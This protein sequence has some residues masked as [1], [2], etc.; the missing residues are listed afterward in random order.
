VTDAPEPEAPAWQ[1]VD[2][3]RH[4]RRGLRRSRIEFHWTWFATVVLLAAALGSRRIP[5]ARP[6]WP[7]LTIWATAVGTAVLVGGSLVLHEASHALVARAYGAK[8]VVLRFALASGAVTTDA[9]QLGP[10]GVA[11]TAIAGPLANAA[12]TLITGGLALAI[13]PNA[14]TG[15]LLWGTPV[16][17]GSTGA[18]LV[19]QGLSLAMADTAT[20]NALAG[21]INLLPIPPFDGGIAVDAVIWHLFGWTGAARAISRIVAAGLIGG[22]I[23][24]FMSGDIISGAL[25]AVIG[26]LIDRL[27]QGR[28]IR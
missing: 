2:D 5:S 10:R 3:P 27:G 19:A 4:P 20:L 8:A 1:D 7:D 22:A 26:L 15:G 13:D 17:H 23:W 24:Q 9:R 16:V 28:R 11:A 21:A 6:D 14:P 25:A 12:V 18:A